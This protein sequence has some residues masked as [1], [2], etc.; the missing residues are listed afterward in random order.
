MI[1][2]LNESTETLF[3]EFQ[4]FKFQGEKKIYSVLFQEARTNC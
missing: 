2:Y 3:T 1:D 4:N